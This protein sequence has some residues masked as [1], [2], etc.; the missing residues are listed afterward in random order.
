[1]EPTGPWLHPSFG[2]VPYCHGPRHKQAGTV[3]SEP[4]DAGGLRL[5]GGG[6]FSP[7]GAENQRRSLRRREDAVGDAEVLR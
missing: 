4:N 2:H 5:R 1:M 7:S 3:R 6:P